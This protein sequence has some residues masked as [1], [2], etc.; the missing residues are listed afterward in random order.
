MNLGLQGW[1]QVLSHLLINVLVR[2]DLRLRLYVVLGSQITIPCLLLMPARVVPNSSIYLSR[3]RKSPHKT[4]QRH[5]AFNIFELHDRKR[6]SVLLAS[7]AMTRVCLHLNRMSVMG[8][9]H[10]HDY[11]IAVISKVTL[12][13][14]MQYRRLAFHQ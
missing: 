3:C 4:L 13:V 8:C 7:R 2:D 12:E 14:F 5:A 9:S 11:S 1:R 10:A 6:V